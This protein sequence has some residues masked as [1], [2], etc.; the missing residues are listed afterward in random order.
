VCGGCKFHKFPYEATI[1]VKVEDE[2]PTLTFNNKEDVWDVIRLIIEETKES[3]LQLNK[4]FDMAT[5]VKTQ[6]PFFACNNIIFNKEYQ[7][8]IERYIYCEN[9]GV[10]PYRGSY[11]EQPSK[12]VQKSHLI[13]KQLNKIKEKAASNGE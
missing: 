8:D 2:Y 1:P 12:W 4:K 13:K 11:S 9:F 10:P 3:S 7:K 5:S 6:L